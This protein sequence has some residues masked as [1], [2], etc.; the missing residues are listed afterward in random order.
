MPDILNNVPIY[1]TLPADNTFFLI[2]DKVTRSTRLS[3]MLESS[4]A[5]NQKTI[6]KLQGTMED[7]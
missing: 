7:S 5:K 6:G 1:I 2:I 4:I 3:R